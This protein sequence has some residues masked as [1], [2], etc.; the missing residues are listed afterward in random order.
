MKTAVPILMYHHVSPSPGLVT[1]SPETFRAHMGWLASHG[2]NA[3]GA[4][5]LESFLSG[6]IVP[7]KS[8]ML[9]FDDGYLDN[10]VYAHPILREFGLRAVLF[11]ISG[12]LGDGLARSHAGQGEA[13]PSCP[14]HRTCMTKVKEGHHDEVMLRWS[15]VE[16]M[17]GAGTFEFHS[18]THTHTRWDKQC[19]DPSE[20]SA[21]LAADLRTSSATLASRLGRTSTHLCWPQGYYDQDYLRVAAETGFDFLYTVEK[22]TVTA[23]SD[24]RR[25]PRIVV[26]DRPGLWFSSRLAIYRRPSL[27]GLY[28]M[29]RG[30]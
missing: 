3:I 15:E 18:H 30:K 23:H 13:V 14:D 16:A 17:R 8:V 27:A 25:L 20:K 4:A 5:E 29:L 7:E 1:V 6:G 26:K 2:Y 19:S 11:L 22:G 28:G 24:P 9:T 12:W 10:W 21:R